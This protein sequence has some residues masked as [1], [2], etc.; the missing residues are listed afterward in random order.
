MKRITSRDHQNRKK[1]EREKQTLPKQLLQ[2]KHKI[3]VELTADSYENTLQ[4][5]YL[6]PP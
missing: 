5:L 2:Q 4:S 1:G 6:N 3:I